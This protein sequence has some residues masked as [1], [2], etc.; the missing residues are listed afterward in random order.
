MAGDVY[1]QGRLRLGGQRPWQVTAHKPDS[2]FPYGRV[3]FKQP[4]AGWTQ[5][6]PKPGQTVDDIFEEIEDG[7]GD[8]NLTVRAL[9]RRDINALA[10]RYDEWMVGNC[11]DTT[12]TKNRNILSKWIRP[13]PTPRSGSSF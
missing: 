5:C 10:D 8:V 11:E 1:R 12:I 3:R 2:R 6:V 13:A 7:L 4:G 9:V